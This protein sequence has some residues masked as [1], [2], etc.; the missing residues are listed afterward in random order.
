MDGIMRILI[1]GSNGFVGSLLMDQLSTTHDV[2]GVDLCYF[3]TDLG[4]SL[5][6]DMSELSAEFIDPFELIICVAGHSSVPISIA[7][8]A[9]AIKNNVVN[10]VRLLDIMRIDQKL[11]YASSS[12]IY[13]AGN[14][15]ANEQQCSYQLSNAYDTTKQI[16]DD[17]ASDAITRG[18]L[19]VGLRF[20]SVVGVSP[21]TRT[22]IAI[23]NMMLT[24]HTTNKFW[25]ADPQLHRSWL[26]VHDAASAI[27]AIAESK[28]FIPGMYNL[29][30][31]DSTIGEVAKAIKRITGYDYTIKNSMHSTYDFTIS[32]DKLTQDYGWKPLADLDKVIS[33]VHSSMPYITE[34][35]RDALP[36]ERPR[37]V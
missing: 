10:M 3:G 28:H 15:D 13:G 29:K 31:F 4:R 25:V 37:S 24:A 2:C 17:I 1:I 20:G 22:D 34:C 18:R 35:R 33:T 21:N 6:I 23:N 30:S 7:D 11:I 8:P 9:G 5:H 36:E 26:D 14:I 16:F 27:A 32:I 19:I 12:S